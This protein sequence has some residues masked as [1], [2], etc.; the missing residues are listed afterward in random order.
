MKKKRDK[1]KHCVEELEEK[2]EKKTMYRYTWIFQ[3]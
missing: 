1:E 3:K 2:R